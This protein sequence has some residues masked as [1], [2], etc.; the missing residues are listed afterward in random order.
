V[1]GRS[2]AGSEGSC[3]RFG[4]QAAVATPSQLP[5]AYHVPVLRSGAHATVA[6]VALAAAVYA[7]ASLSGGWLGTPPW[8]ETWFAEADIPPTPAHYDPWSR[9]DYYGE[10]HQAQNSNSGRARRGPRG[11]EWLRPRKG[12]ER[13]S[14][15]IAVVGYALFAV[16]A[17][18][19]RDRPGRNEEPSP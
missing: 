1:N 5:L 12:R 10:M 14:A 18:P 3:R 17:W 9:P 2:A 13:I 19:R 4:P 7:T 11:A 16:A 8:W 6:V 15:S